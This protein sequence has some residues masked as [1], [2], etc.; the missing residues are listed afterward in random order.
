MECSNTE[1]VRVVNHIK[2]I[3]CDTRTKYDTS[4]I[5]RIRKRF[6][7]QESDW[8][9]WQLIFFLRVEDCISPRYSS[10]ID[11]LLPDDIIINVMIIVCYTWME[12]S[13][14]ALIPSRRNRTDRGTIRSL[15]TISLSGDDSHAEYNQLMIRIFYCLPYL[16]EMVLQR[17]MVYTWDRE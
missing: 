10:P 12:W 6:P 17:S 9:Q 8:F 5:Y 14:G 7:K 11:Q 1:E 16:W 4:S 3:I 13:R 15:G 2:W